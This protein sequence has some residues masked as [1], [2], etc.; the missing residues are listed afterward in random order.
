M[1]T[2]RIKIC[3]ILIVVFISISCDRK[4]EPLSSNS[5]EYSGVD[6]VVVYQ[7][8]PSDSIPEDKIICQAAYGNMPNNLKPDFN[9][10]FCKDNFGFPY[11]F[12]DKDELTGKA[13][14]T[15]TIIE[16][17][18]LPISQSTQYK[19]TYDKKGR[20]TKYSIRGP[21]TIYDCDI[22]HD[23][24][25]QIKQITDRRK[26]ILITYNEFGNILSLSEIT[27]DGQEN[28]ILTFFYTYVVLPR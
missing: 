3:T 14:Q 20:I 1:I 24:Q 23:N 12:P 18:H 21:S 11:Y 16:N 25:N 15:I 2:Q 4:D 26:K 22:I 27:P 5:N 13:D 6:R 7:D 17:K 9:I 28:K 10:N 8:D 19:L